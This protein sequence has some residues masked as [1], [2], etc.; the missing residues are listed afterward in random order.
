M[1]RRPRIGLD[2]DGTIADT[3]QVKHDWLIENRDLAV[4]LSSCSR[5][6][7]CARGIEPEEYDQ[8]LSAVCGRESTL[9]TPECEGAID[10]VLALASF[11]D[12]FLITDRGRHEEW[13]RWGQEWL[14]DK[15]I[16]DLFQG[17]L[18]T[19]YSPLT[20]SREKS[21]AQLCQENGTHVLV[22][23]DRENLVGLSDTVGVP[24][25]RG[26]V[27]D[28]KCDP[29]PQQASSWSEVVALC[30]AMFLS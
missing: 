17:A 11:A 6:G 19:E 24:Y 15:G 26:G 27:A 20:K 2:F 12:L 21:K 22:D 28:S 4:P 1:K 18:S 23:D 3:A 29:E 5:S 10:G 13:L 8:M 9:A 30:R 7:L 14:Q 25:A 16:W